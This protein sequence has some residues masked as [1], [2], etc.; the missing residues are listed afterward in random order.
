MPRPA[1]PEGW[2]ASRKSV[3]AKTASHRGS[4]GRPGIPGK[5][6]FREQIPSNND[7]PERHVTHIRHPSPRRNCFSKALPGTRL[8][9]LQR[10]QASS[11]PYHAA[12]SFDSAAWAAFELALR[13]LPIARP[14]CAYPGL[15][16]HKRVFNEIIS[17]CFVS[18]VPQ[19]SQG[20][21]HDLP[22]G[23]RPW[24]APRQGRIGAKLLLGLI[25]CFQSSSG[26]TAYSSSMTHGA[27]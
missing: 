21:Q 26:L 23:N 17:G 4:N 9:R 2:F 18:G 11:S 24:H 12:A 5:L 25:Q 20:G 8:S 6:G 22:N 14:G 13:V 27:M 15:P 19:E 3:A 7:M 10:D 1:P 16:E